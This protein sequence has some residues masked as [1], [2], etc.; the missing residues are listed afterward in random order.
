MSVEIQVTNS[1]A[2]TAGCTD[3][4]TAAAHDEGAAAMHHMKVAIKAAYTNP[5]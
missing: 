4:N 1:K 3:H 2:S 5:A